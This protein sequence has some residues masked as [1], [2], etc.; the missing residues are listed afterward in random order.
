MSEELEILWAI[1]EKAWTA[2]MEQKLEEALRAAGF[3]SLFEWDAAD[4][5]SV[6]AFIES[7]TLLAWLE[8]FP[9]GSAGSKRL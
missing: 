5:K 7:A 1:H 6:S 4:P 3:E 2:W 9:Q 8:R